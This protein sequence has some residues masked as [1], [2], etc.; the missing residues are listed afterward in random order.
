MEGYAKV[1][2]L[3]SKYDEFAVLRR[4]ERLNIQSLL[5]SQ[6]EIVHLEDSLARLVARDADDPEKEFHAKDWWSLAHGEGETGREQWRLIRKIRKKLDR[7]SERNHEWRVRRL[8]LI[9]MRRRSSPQTSRNIQLGK[10]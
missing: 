8:L 6:A 9:A 1:A 5:Y 10:T 2:H 7:Y 3:M 4:F